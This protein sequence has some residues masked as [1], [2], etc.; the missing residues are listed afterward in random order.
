M[1]L[2]KKQLRDITRTALGFTGVLCA[3]TALIWLGNRNDA[4]TNAESLKAGILTAH[5]VKAAFETVSGRLVDRPIEE[6]MTVE[7]GA[8]LLAIDGTD[9]GLSIRQTE[10]LI[11]QAD[12]QIAAE[13]EGIR[14]ALAEANTEEQTLWR[15]IEASEAARK[16][17]SA[18]WHRAEADWKRAQRL[19]PQGA[20]AQSD[21]DA[22]KAAAA[23]AREGLSS[24]ER[25][26]DAAC[27]GARAE[28]RQKLSRTGSAEGMRLDAVVNAR[29]AA[30]N[31]RISLE[32]LKAGREASAAALEQLKVNQSRLT[33]K[34]SEKAKVLEVLYEK[35]ELVSP[36]A[37]AVL[38]ESERLYFDIYV[39]ENKVTGFQEGAKVTCWSPALNQNVRGTVL[40][41]TAAPD[42]ADLKMVRERGQAD[43]TLFKVRINVEPAEGPLPA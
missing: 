42:F 40:S 12:A 27:V 20:M 32:S 7:A 9:I 13:E 22:L 43:L 14:L 6:G 10:A 3:A 35:G 15:Q 30:E 24:A 34:A 11:H 39:A 16:S 8:K 31:R 4:V 17:A 37:P 29:Q 5:Q 25:A 2:S 36:N 1:N 19:L 41:V 23:S 28:D 38:L 21:F 33:L 18:E 26:V